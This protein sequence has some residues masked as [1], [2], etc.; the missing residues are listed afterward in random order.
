[1]AIKSI[2]RVPPNAFIVNQLVAF[3][4]NMI[5]NNC[6]EQ[7]RLLCFKVDLGLLRSNDCS[8]IVYT[9][10]LKQL[11]RTSLMNCHASKITISVMFTKSLFLTD[12][13]R[14]LLHEYN[15]GLNCGLRTT[16]RR[17][18]KQFL[19]PSFNNFLLINHF[20]EHSH[21]CTHENKLSAAKVHPGIC[22][23]TETLNIRYNIKILV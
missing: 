21:G 11:I 19:K 3:P 16:S 15:I 12:T 8:S 18:Q 7:K 6:Q 2:E 5:N 4:Y 1:M 9:R 22:S 14:C 17:K 20:I 13:I 10:I 23:R